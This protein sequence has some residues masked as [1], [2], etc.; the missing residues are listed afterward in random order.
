MKYSGCFV[1]NTCAG[2]S[3]K[4]KPCGREW[5]DGYCYLCLGILKNSI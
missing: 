1:M 3:L 2:P 4:D 5:G